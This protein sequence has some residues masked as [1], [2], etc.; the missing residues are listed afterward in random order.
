MNYEFAVRWLK[1]FRTSAEDVCALYE[2]DGFL[3]EDPMLDQ[4]GVD[5]MPDLLRLFSLY[6]NKD[7]TNG[8]GVHNFRV[9]GYVGDERSGLILWEWSPE[10]CANFTGLDVGGKDFITQGHTYHEYNQRGKIVRESSW[11][12]ASAILRQVDLE[13]PGLGVVTP[14]KQPT[15]EQQAVAA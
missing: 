13:F 14:S 8:L 2:E 3:F 4:H 1:C 9:R 15:G 10:D 7:R 5:N 12:D 6:A 11:W